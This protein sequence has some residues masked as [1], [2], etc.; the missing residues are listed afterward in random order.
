MSHTP[1]GNGGPRTPCVWL[2][3]GGPKDEPTSQQ[4]GGWG[5]GVQG[6]LVWPLVLRPH[7]PDYPAEHNSHPPPASPTANRCHCRMGR[8]HGVRFGLTGLR[9]RRRQTRVFASV[10]TKKRRP[11]VAYE[12]WHGI[13]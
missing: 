1:D 11:M 13:L 7:G 6:G 8:A 12:L 3:S 4:R 2:A 9:R 5:W 10:H